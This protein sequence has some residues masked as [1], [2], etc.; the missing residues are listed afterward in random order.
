MAGSM[1]RR[2][3]CTCESPI[4]PRAHAPHR[5]SMRRPVEPPPGRG[6][7]A[8]AAW[9]VGHRVTAVAR[10]RVLRAAPRSA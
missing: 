3:D 4:C 1:D 7:G 6:H 9:L 2:D 5:P 8:Q 10:R